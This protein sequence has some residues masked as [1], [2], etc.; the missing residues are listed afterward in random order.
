MKNKPLTLLTLALFG[1]L[2][3]TGC[4]IGDNEP[5]SSDTAAATSEIVYRPELVW[6]TPDSS[7]AYDTYIVSAGD[8]R[9]MFDPNEDSATEPSR[10]A[11]Y[12]THY[13]ADED[14]VQKVYDREGLIAYM[15]EQGIEEVGEAGGFD[16]PVFAVTWAQLNAL[17]CVAMQEAMGVSHEYGLDACLAKG[18]VS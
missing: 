8:I 15:A 3:L 18:I 5:P 7:F 1:V 17:D 6:A 13:D 12:F 4:G 14:G 11:V 16:D 9:P 10:Y 2:L